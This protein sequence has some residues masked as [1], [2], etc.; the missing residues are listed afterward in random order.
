MLARKALAAVLA[1]PP[2]AGAAASLSRA[3]H[4][5]APALTTAQNSAAPSHVTTMFHDPE[6]ASRLTKRQR[7]VYETPED[8]PTLPSVKDHGYLYGFKEEHL[9]GRSEAVRRAL[10]TRTGN[11]RGSLTFRR[12]ELL[13][14]FA[15]DPFNTGE[16]V[17][18]VRAPPPL[19]ARASARSAGAGLGLMPP[20]PAALKS[21]SQRPP[22]T[23]PPS[24][25]PV[26]RWPC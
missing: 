15:S 8:L 21:S 10:S 3:V 5:C 6:T 13:R 16:P 7:Q 11:I 24:L 17:V 18:Q 2:V 14:K 1:Q 22:S 9:A 20:P 23:P 12:S 25:P 26:R 19:A 4:A